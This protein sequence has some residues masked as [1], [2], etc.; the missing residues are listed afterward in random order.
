MPFDSIVQLDVC[1]LV[2]PGSSIINTYSQ[3]FFAFQL[4]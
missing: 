4:Y 2:I 1:I 3:K